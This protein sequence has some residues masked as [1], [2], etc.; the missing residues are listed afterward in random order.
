MFY[1][2]KM[3]TLYRNLTEVK[4]R[5]LVT[6]QE[7]LKVPYERIRNLFHVLKEIELELH[8]L[9]SEEDLEKH[10]SETESDKD[11]RET[12][13]EEERSAV[14]LY[15]SKQRAIREKIKRWEH[16]CSEIAYY[17]QESLE[18]MKQTAEGTVHRLLTELETGGNVRFE[19]GLPSCLW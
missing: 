11:A 2:M 16:K 1:N 18:R 15:R 5:L 3:K 9:K 8:F 19:D 7:I 17:H 14:E 6:K 12:K 13:A 4:A 10:E